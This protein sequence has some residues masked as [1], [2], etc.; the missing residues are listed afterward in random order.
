VP[1]G[2]AGTSVLDRLEQLYTL[3]GGPG[4]NRLGYSPAEEEACRLAESWM[5]TEG[6]ATRRDAVGNVYGTRA[7]RVRDAPPVVVGSHLDSVPQGGRFDGALGV[8]AAIE[9]L[10]GLELTDRPVTV[11]CFRDEE[12][13][14]FGHGMFG[15]RALCGRLVPGELEVTDAA[16][17]TRAEALAALGYDLPPRSGWLES[18]APAAFVEAHVEQG[19]VLEASGSALGVVTGVVGIRWLRVRFQGAPAHAGTT[20]VDV[21]RDALCAAALLILGVR[22][23][24]S[25]EPGAVGTVG[26]VACRPGA[27]NV[28]PGVAELTVDLR[29]PTATQLERLCALVG[30]RAQAAAAAHACD[31]EVT[32]DLAHAPVA[33]SPA[34]RD[35]LA[36]AAAGLEHPAIELVSGAGHDAAVLASAVVPTGMLFVRSRDGGASHCPQESTADGDVVCCVLALQTALRELTD[37]SAL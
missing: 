7:G 6:W 16:G 13:S 12:G 30:S 1:L 3:G 17:V 22:E 15:S 24:V 31:L 34:V 27:V 32:E 14:R 18:L 37:Q 5:A 29:A 36:R 25:A 33:M 11:V 21:R 26:A 20:P 8:V 28:I 9:A 19:P 35:V 2:Q 4:A 10:R 23:L